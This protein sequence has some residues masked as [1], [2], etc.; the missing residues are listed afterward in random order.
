MD[1][2]EQKEG[3]GW[4]MY[5]GDCVEVMAGLK[6]NS[7]GYSIFS[8]PFA[9]LFT[10]SDSPRDM[11]NCKTDE[12]FLNHFAFVC[13]ELYRL[14]QPGRL[15][16]IHCMDLP[17]MKERDGYI[18]L[19]DFPSTI[20]QAFENEGFIYHSRCIIWKDPLL[21]AVRTK[22]L[23]LMHKQLMKDSSRCRNGIP[24][25]IITMRKPGEN[26]HLIRH[27]M[28]MDRF[29]GENEPT[30]KGIEYSHNVW[31]KYASPVWMDINQ[32]RTLNIMLA[33]EKND[34]RHICP[35]Q[36]DTIARCLELWSNKGDIVLSPFA[37][38]GSEGHESLRMERK[39]IG[40]ELKQSYFNEAVK[41]L[42]K[43]ENAPKQ[44][45]LI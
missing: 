24:D 18:G 12:E 31:R 38:I 37:G 8:P 34:E 29:F 28:G 5:N 13:R 43:I 23:G 27:P 20:R 26:D 16:S 11:G 6:D 19:K 45:E 36:L 15:V 21:E 44:M 25:Q 10:Y 39:F 2:I 7:I 14:I 22:S 1:V 30:E 32:T 42:Q 4:I 33:R 3:S 9:S 40:I 17:A 41:N 35:L